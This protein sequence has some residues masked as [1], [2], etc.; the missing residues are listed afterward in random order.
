MSLEYNTVAK[1][2]IGNSIK[3][4][5]YVDDE[6][7]VPFDSEATDTQIQLSKDVYNSF[8]SHNCGLDLYKYTETENWKEKAEYFFKGRDLFIVDWQ[9][10]KTSPEHKPT[11]EILS[12]A[13]VKESL[14]FICIYTTTETTHFKE[15]IYKLN[16]YFS[17]FDPAVVAKDLVAITTLIEDAGYDMK[18]I[19]DDSILGFFKDMVIYKERSG[20]TFGEITKLIKERTSTEIF[21]SITGILDRKKYKNTLFGYC[22]IG[23][24]LNGEELNSNH[25]VSFEARNF[26][27][28]NFLI[29]NHTVI[30]IANKDEIKPNVLYEKFSEAI[31]ES[32]GNFLT[33]MGLE[34]RN[35]FKESSAFIGKDID[36]IDELAFF[37][38]KQ[39]ASPSEAFYDFLKD[40]WKAQ[41]ASFLYNKNSQLKIFDSLG[42]YKTKR[43]IDAK[44]TAFSADPIKHEQHLGK[45]NY[46]YNILKTS[47]P[48]KDQFRFG[49]IFRVYKND[50]TETNE[51]LLC[52]TAHCDCLYSSVKINNQFYFVKGSK[53][54][55]TNALKEGDTAFNSY[56]LTGKNE[57]NIVEWLDKPFTIYVPNEKNNIKAD[58]NVRI[59]EDDFN[60]KYHSTLKENYAQRIANKGFTY[61]LHVGIFYADKK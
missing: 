50:G 2:I 11:L 35:H 48:D 7:A 17:P 55:L 36:D 56:I 15:I 32:S 21:N 22:A 31:I 5:I 3:S 14:H 19:F 27:E 53:G 43:G 16:S 44:L 45:L 10:N 13:V 28:N 8:Y 42:D 58:I 20:K 38:H 25:K 33:L 60:L 12:E 46:Y 49:D 47:R 18:K 57:V 9:L 34:M 59:G 52:I 39:N 41:A 4:V 51:Y 54:N 30:L 29:V 23:F 61:P 24:L 26:S 1:E 6:L 40:L 37:H